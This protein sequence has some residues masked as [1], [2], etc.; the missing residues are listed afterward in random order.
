MKLYIKSSS[1]DIQTISVIVNLQSYYSA[2]VAAATYHKG[3]E[4]FFIPDGPLLPRDKEIKIDPH[5]QIVE[6]YRS[7]IISVKEL[8][9]DYYELNLYYKNHSDDNSYYFGMLAKDDQDNNILTFDA[10]LRL[11]NH[12]AHRTPESKNNKKK[13]KELLLEETHGQKTRPLF[14]S[15]L[16]NNEEFD[17]YLDAYQKVDEWIDHAVKIMKKRLSKHGV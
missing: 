4:D 13:Q 14:N 11:S 15:I 3:D 16:V 8:M 5:S 17:N 2:D 7:F 10:T 9:E 12:P 1:Y 6:D